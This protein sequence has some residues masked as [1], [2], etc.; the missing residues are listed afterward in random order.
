MY[1]KVLIRMFIHATY[2]TMAGI[3]YLMACI[4]NFT[5]AN[6]NIKRRDMRFPDFLLILLVCHSTIDRRDRT[7]QIAAV[8]EI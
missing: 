4:V 1:V 8:L 2:V 3:L 5:T 6:N 7:S